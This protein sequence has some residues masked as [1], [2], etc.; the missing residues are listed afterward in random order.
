MAAAAILPLHA[1]LIARLEAQCPSCPRWYAEDTRPPGALLPLGEVGGHKENPRGGFFQH[2]GSLLRAELRWF[3]DDREDTDAERG[4][5]PVLRIWGEVLPALQEVKLTLAG[6]Q[7]I[8]GT[9]ELISS[10]RDTDG[11]R[12]AVAHYTARTL[13]A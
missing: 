8:I 3:S 1:A 4:V 6:H 12:N 10:Y 13:S 11:Y 9:V 5:A 2:S 7:Q